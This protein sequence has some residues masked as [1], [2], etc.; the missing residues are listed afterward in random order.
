M[1]TGG[2]CVTLLSRPHLSWTSLTEERLTEVSIGANDGHLLDHLLLLELDDGR[3]A[4]RQLAEEG[5]VLGG[6]GGRAGHHAEGGRGG[7]VSGRERHTRS[8]T[9]QCSGTT[10]ENSQSGFFYWDV[11]RLK[12]IH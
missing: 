4:L 6:V 8:Q 1:V 5:G 9:R 10:S 12:I 2:R 3:G 7:T 11:W